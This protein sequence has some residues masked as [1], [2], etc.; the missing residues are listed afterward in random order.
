MDLWCTFYAISLW[1]K[2]APNHL[3]KRIRPDC[4]K[5]F[6]Q[7]MQQNRYQ[8]SQDLRLIRLNPPLGEYHERQKTSL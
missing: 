6:L 2:V 3:K 4:S 8:I 7:E 5:L 1:A